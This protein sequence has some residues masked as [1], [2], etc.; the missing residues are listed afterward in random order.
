[1]R[2]SLACALVFVGGCATADR[3]GGQ[4]ADASKHDSSQQQIDSPGQQI[5]APQN[6]G[7]DAA[8]AIT[9]SE[10]GGNTTVAAGQTISCNNTVT[11]S[12]NIWYRAY[13]LSDFPAI[14]GGLH[15]TG[16]TFAIEECS[17]AGTVTVKIGNYSGSVDALSTSQISSLAQATTSPADQSASTVTVPIVADIAAGGKF[18]VQVSSPVN[19]N[20]YFVLGTTN[21]AETHPGYWSS[22]GCSQTTPETTTA[23]AQT[24][25]NIIDVNGTH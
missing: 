6:G 20:G 10:T 2:S 17:V 13:Q 15:I 1:M 7:A 3:G 19:N 12:D 16:V 14:T 4:H 11:T 18:V 25:H 22:A 23:A 9:L 24:T 8:L 5:D 21:T